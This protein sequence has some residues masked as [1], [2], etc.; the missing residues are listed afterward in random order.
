MDCV[1]KAYNI[2]KG[3]SVDMLILHDKRKF[4]IPSLLRV[5][6]RSMK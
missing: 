1:E 3:G 4:K 2:K 6:E 5:Q